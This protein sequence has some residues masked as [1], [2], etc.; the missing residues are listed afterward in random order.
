M[1]SLQSKLENF[2]II[3][4]LINFYI[5]IFLPL[6]EMILYENY[7]KYYERLGAFQNYKLIHLSKNHLNNLCLS[8]LR[9]AIIQ[10][11]KK[12]ID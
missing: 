11:I 10:L 12:E 7:T 9:L 4:S 5:H 8:D 2:L 1:T 6:I 3:F